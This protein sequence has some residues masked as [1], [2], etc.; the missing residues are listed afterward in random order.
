MEAGMKFITDYDILKG[1]KNHDETAWENFYNF[2]APLIRLHGRD[3]GLKNENLEDLVQNVMLTMAEQMPGFVYDPAKGRFRDYLR[4]IIRA[5]ANDML[6]KIYRQ[7]RLPADELEEYEQLDRY[8][9]EWKEHI[10]ARSLEMLKS[11]V[12]LQHYQIF[13]LLDINHHSVNELAKLYNMPPVSIY[14]IRSRVE[15]RLKKIVR[16]LDN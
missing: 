9:E 1:T 14:S 16:D 8:D 5:R 11:A 4:K 3:C 12:R 10:L 15:A 6:R 7:E 2:Y 13:Y